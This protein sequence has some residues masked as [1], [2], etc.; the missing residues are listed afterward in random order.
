[1]KG[2]IYGIKSIKKFSQI[3]ETKKKVLDSEKKKK[4]EVKDIEKK[5]IATGAYFKEYFFAYKVQSYLILK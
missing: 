1:M 2:K 5:N 4:Q 3:Q